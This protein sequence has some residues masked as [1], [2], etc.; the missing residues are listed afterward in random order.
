[1][2]ASSRSS[3]I[4]ID[5]IKSKY[6]VCQS[7][8][9]ASDSIPNSNYQDNDYEDEDESHENRNQGLEPGFQHNLSFLLDKVD[10]LLQKFD[11]KIENQTATRENFSDDSS[12]VIDLILFIALG[13]LLI[14]LL[15]T[16]FR[17][18]KYS[19]HQT[20]PTGYFPTAQNNVY[21]Q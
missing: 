11:Q 20:P 5:K 12:S 7:F 17:L 16:F 9:L 4:F 18:G 10:N 6:S 3:T 13:I 2:I 8:I 15:D 21:R 1:M 19:S 14:F